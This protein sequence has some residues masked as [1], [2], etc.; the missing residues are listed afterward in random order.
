MNTHSL[1]VLMVISVHM[2]S[3]KIFDFC[4]SDIP[5]LP[6]CFSF[7]TVNKRPVHSIFTA[8][9]FVLLCFLSR[10]SLS[11]M[12]LHYNSKELSRIPKHKKAV[13]C[14]MEKIHVLDKLYA[15]MSYRA[16]GHDQC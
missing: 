7:H 16:D 8:K 3:G 12:G 9:V 14:L 1:I 2:H 13:M 5:G 6:S 11:K 15:D 10:I 4:D